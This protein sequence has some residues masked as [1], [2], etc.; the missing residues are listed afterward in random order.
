MS[1]YVLAM[2]CVLHG[3]CQRGYFLLNNPA[4]VSCER[5]VLPM[6]EGHSAKN[7]NGETVVWHA[8]G[9]VTQDFPPKNR[10]MMGMF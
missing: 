1:V 4:L 2:A 10:R 3:S 5:D 7:K 6:V 9:C 8:Q